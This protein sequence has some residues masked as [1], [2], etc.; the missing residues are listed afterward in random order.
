MLK[1]ERSKSNYR[2]YSEQAIY[3]L[4][5]IEECKKIHLPLEEI[6]RKLDINKS[7]SL[8]SAEVEKHVDEV[9]KQIQQLRTEISAILPLL[10]QLEDQQKSDLSK[11]LTKES[12]ALMQSVLSLTS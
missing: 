1:A 3:D 7:N 11:K 6:K 5:F 9:T 2:M 4:K 12:S 10:E 8:K